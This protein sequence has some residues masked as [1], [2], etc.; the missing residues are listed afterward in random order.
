VS[1]WVY[2]RHLRWLM[3]A[4]GMYATT[5]PRPARFRSR[6]V[7]ATACVRGGRSDGPMPTRTFGWADAHP[8]AAWV[9]IGRAVRIRLARVRVCRS[10]RTS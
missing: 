8:G 1:R 3:A 9:G 5:D 4:A 6:D 2:R 10:G 7:V